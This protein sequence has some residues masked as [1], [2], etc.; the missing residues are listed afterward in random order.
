MPC[1]G[2]SNNLVLRLFQAP[3][4]RTSC[5][6]ILVLAISLVFQGNMWQTQ[7][8]SYVAD[9]ANVISSLGD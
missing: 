9:E 3:N 1:C 2:T 6:W 4:D 7:L 5:L 8:N